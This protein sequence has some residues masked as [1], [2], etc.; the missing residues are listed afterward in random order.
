M[1]VK[2]SVIGRFTGALRDRG[3]GGGGGGG[4]IKRDGFFYPY[5]KTGGGGQTKIVS[6]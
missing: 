5:K 4:G 3:S 2:D 6:C 1:R